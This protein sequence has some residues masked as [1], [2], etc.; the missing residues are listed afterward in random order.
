MEFPGA[1]VPSA[2]VEVF[3]DTVLPRGE[4]QDGSQNHAG[5]NGRAFEV[6]D[7]AAAATCRERFGGD[8]EAREAAHATTY[9]VDER[10]GVPAAVEPRG[11]SQHGGRDAEGDDIR[12]RIEL[13]AQRRVLVAPAGHVT[14][15]PVE[16]ECEGCHGGGGVEVRPGPALQV[17]HREKYGADAAG[18]IGEGEEV[19]EVKAAH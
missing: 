1:E 19:R 5:R 15:Q 2:A 10:H 17:S 13:A 6:G 14:V 9:K 16:E 4:G 12:Q 8:V 3:S 7:L 18:G 11:I